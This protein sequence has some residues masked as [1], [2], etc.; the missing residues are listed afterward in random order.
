[1]EFANREGHCRIT[2]NY[3]TNDGFRLAGWVKYQRRAQD[4]LSAER[5]K[6]LEAV[7]GWTWDVFAD[8]WEMGY[9][10]L[11][12][13]SNLEGHCRVSQNLRT[14]EGFRLG[15]WVGR[16][17]AAKDD[18]PAE[19]KIRLEALPGWVWEVHAER[20]ETGYRH[21]SEFAEREGHCR[22]PRNYRAKDGFLLGVWV[23]EQR[24]AQND[25][26]AERKERLEAISSWVWDIFADK[27]E[28]GFRH[29]TEFAKREGHCRVLVNY[30]TND[31]YRLGSWAATQ[32]NAKECLPSERKEQLEAVP[33]WTWDAFADQ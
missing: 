16:Q 9:R 4:N 17:R 22:V 18:I 7:S 11:A 1:M 30:R 24:I 26:S 28:T 15:T 8:Q 31:G 25:L 20:W 5:K 32:R 12:E 3:R 13:F 23:K 29:L 33:G 27:W 6:Q 21:L 19:Q 14:S 2:D 10:A